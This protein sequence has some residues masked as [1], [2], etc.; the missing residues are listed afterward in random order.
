[1]SED[2]VSTVAQAAASFDRRD[3]GAWAEYFADDVDYR[4]LE[5]AIDDHVEVWELSLTLDHGRRWIADFH[6][7]SLIR[8]GT[9]HRPRREATGKPR[10]HQGE[11]SRSEE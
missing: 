9:G 2:N 11:Q 8:L 7:C 1:M 5:G 4:A 10:R 6:R 3:L